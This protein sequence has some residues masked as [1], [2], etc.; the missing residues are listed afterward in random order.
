LVLVNKI[1]IVINH[2]NIGDNS[3]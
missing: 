1:D 2:F 3:F